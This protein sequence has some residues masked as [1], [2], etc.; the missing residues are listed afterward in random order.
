MFSLPAQPNRSLIDG[1]LV[2]QTVAGCTEPIGSRELARELGLEPTRVNRLLKTLAYLGLIQQRP[3]RKY[4]PGPGIHV[5]AAQA[6]VGSRLLQ[7]ALPSLTRLKRFNHIVALGVLWRDRVCYLYHAGP[8]TPPGGEIGHVGAYPV[9]Y[10][11]I[12]CALLA[13]ESRS[14]LSDRLGDTIQPD[15]IRLL[16]KRLPHYQRLGYARVEQPGGKIGLGF[17]LAPHTQAAIGISGTFNPIQEEKLVRALRTAADQINQRE[18]A[19]ATPP[20]P[21]DTSTPG[22]PDT[23]GSPAPTPL[24]YSP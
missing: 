15:Q 11:G 6:L 21:P 10:S 17:P 12:G 14:E 4:L 9:Y 1:L 2:L 19:P 20:S 8:S 22:S 24:E 3:D 18:L 7:H 16:T 13:R 5:L 23:P